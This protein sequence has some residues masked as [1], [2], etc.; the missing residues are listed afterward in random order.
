MNRA[1]QPRNVVLVPWRL[2]PTISLKAGSGC[3]QFLWI[4][5]CTIYPP[6]IR[7]HNLDICNNGLQKRIPA[8]R[9]GYEK[10]G[11]VFLMNRQ[12]LARLLDKENPAPTG[13]VY[14]AFG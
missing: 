7:I 1:L 5:E 13:T 11:K 4:C 2:C 8:L 9:R 10:I 3:L 14:H 6:S 12:T